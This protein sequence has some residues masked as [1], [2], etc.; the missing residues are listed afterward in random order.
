MFYAKQIPDTNTYQN[1]YL[2]FSY[3]SYYKLMLQVTTFKPVNVLSVE[4]LYNV[5]VEGKASIGIDDGSN[6][7]FSDGSNTLF[8][9]PADASSPFRRTVEEYTFDNP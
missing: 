5:R 3:I 7:W 6:T 1:Y 9:K 2:L 8:S 4:R